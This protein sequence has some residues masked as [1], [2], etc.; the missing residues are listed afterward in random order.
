MSQK[1]FVFYLFWMAIRWFIF[2]DDRKMFSTRLWHF[3]YRQYKVFPTR[4]RTFTS[5]NHD[6]L[7][8]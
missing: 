3:V 8:F 5:C 1:V 4:L 2:L 7:Y 6:E